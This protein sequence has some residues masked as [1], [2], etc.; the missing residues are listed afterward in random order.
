MIKSLVQCNARRSWLALAVFVT[1]LSGCGELLPKPVKTPPP[2]LYSLDNIQTFQHQV[3]Q[4]ARAAAPV[5]VVS[6]P[7]ADAGFESARIIYLRQAHKLEYF[8]QSQW[9]DTPAAMLS[10]L[11]VAAL[12]RNG[13]FKA[14]VQA[15]TSTAGQ[16]RLDVDV[17]RL[18][19]EFLV[20]PSRVRFTLR[21]HLLDTATRKVVAW[22]EFDAVIPSASEDTYGGVMAANQAVRNVLEELAVFCSQVAQ[23]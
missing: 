12:E 19:H 5:L 14:V 7:R 9:V 20:Q 17:I 11:I 22:R 21:A 18:Q 1:F 4:P 16:F 23:R 10:P 6:T 3:I 13:T 2:V 15:P 8:A